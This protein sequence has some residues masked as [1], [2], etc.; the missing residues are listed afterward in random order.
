MPRF[1][2]QVHPAHCVGLVDSSHI[3]FVGAG[4]QS[5]IS[6]QVMTPHTD[7]THTAAPQAAKQAEL[8]LQASLQHLSSQVGSPAQY[9]LQQ[10][11][12]HEMQ[13]EPGQLMVQ[14]EHCPL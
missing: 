9:P 12:P 6:R 10:F 13:F 11:S 8:P 2:L 7:V 4:V 14:A 1:G 5:E 3:P